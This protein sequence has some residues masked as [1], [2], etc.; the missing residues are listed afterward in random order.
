MYLNDRAYWRNVPA[1]VWEYY[2]GG[3]Q[4]MKKWLSYREDEILGRALRPEEAREV[5]NMA[6]RIAAIV[7]L[8][9][10]LDR[11]YR[12]VAGATYA[13]KG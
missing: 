11:N 4:V 3:Y 1:A 6:R 8:Q 7:L 9:P 13:W 5:M 2:I 10:E 12:A